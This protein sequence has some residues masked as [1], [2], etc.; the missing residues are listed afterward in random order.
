M[1]AEEVNNTV[2]GAV[3]DQPGRAIYDP[4]GAAAIIAFVVFGV[5][6]VGLWT[7]YFRTRPRAKWTRCVCLG[8]TFMSIGFICRFSRRN[9]INAW[10][11]LFETLLI[12]LSPC[13][14][15]AQDYILISRL[16]VHLD[17]E[18]A[19][20]LPRRAIVVTYVLADVVTVLTQLAGTA[21]TITFGNL[22]P[23][24]VK[25]STLV[26]AGLWVQFAFFTSFLIVYIVFWRRLGTNFELDQGGRLSSPIALM[27]M[28]GV[29]CF[30]LLIRSIYRVAE[31]T[32][33]A[34]STLGQSEVAFY[35]LDSVM[36]A[37]NVLGFLVVWPPSCLDKRPE[38]MAAH[39][40]SLE[41]R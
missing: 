3:V 11:W 14:F 26:T 16:A 34:G 20:V 2:A 38:V 23:I 29:S 27:R 12:L 39:M 31:Y 41:R 5:F 19:L 13:L 10:S 35:I 24:G 21:M 30:L 1:K 17:A 37:L 4:N 15:L 6:A 22:V 8:S 40:L 9:G 32:A 28:L 33:G 18:D 25:A 7:R 36:M